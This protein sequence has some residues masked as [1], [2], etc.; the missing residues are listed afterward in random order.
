MVMQNLKK[1]IQIWP[2]IVFTT[3]KCMSKFCLFME[4]VSEI[5]YELM[6]PQV[7]RAYNDNSIIQCLSHSGCN[8]F[9]LKANI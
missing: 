4:V 7:A 9:F 8:F 6:S 2:R 1:K 3:T 5:V